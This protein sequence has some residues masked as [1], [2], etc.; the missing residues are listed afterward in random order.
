MARWS[1]AGSV[2]PVAKRGRSLHNSCIRSRPRERNHVIDNRAPSRAAV[3]P[4]S[5]EPCVGGSSELKGP[6]A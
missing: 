1:I 3:P 2:A 6:D 5:L 4:T